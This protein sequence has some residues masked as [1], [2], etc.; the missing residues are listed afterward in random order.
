MLLYSL[1]VMK[2]H[3][4]LMML[5]LGVMLICHNISEFVNDKQHK[6]SSCYY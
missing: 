4:R 6:I 5:H 3:V 1:S 2:A